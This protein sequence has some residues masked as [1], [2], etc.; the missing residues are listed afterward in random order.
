MPGAH[1][2]HVPFLGVPN[3]IAPLD[4]FG[5]VPSQHLPGNEGGHVV[6][7]VVLFG[8]L[9]SYPLASG[10]ASGEIQHLIFELAAGRIYDRM[11]TFV[12]AGGAA[13]R[14]I[15]LG[16]YD[17]PNPA[18][19]GEPT[20]LV[21]RTDVTSTA[22]LN[23]SFAVLPLTD[24]AG[25]PTPWTVPADGFYWQAM[26]QSSNA[27]K[28]ASTA[29]DYRENYLPARRTVSGTG[30]LPAVAAVGTNPVAP[31]LICALVEQGIVLPF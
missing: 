1:K 6:S 9:L 24:G 3:G 16:V 7:G 11:L 15:Q 27:I 14:T 21:A 28:F 22:T 19:P 31:L 13:G 8:T 18:V 10:G 23:G 20:N 12:V 25:T 26:I 4:S 17:Q 29:V 5:F 30:A 2:D